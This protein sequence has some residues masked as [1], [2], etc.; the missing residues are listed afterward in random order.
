M[1]DAAVLIDHDG[2][3]WTLTLNR[4]RRLNALD[5]GDR[6]ELLAALRNADADPGCRAVVLTGAGGVFSAGGDIRSMSQAPDETPVRLAVLTDLA[7]AVI[8]SS[9]PVIAAV[10]GGAFGLGLSLTA[11]A[12]YVV[13]ANDARFIASFG[14]IGLIGDTGLFWSLAQRVGSSRAKELMLFATE[15]DASRAHELGLVNEMTPPAEV[16]STARERAHTLA[17]AAPGVIAGT[18]RIFAQE[19]QDL[20]AVLAAETETQLALLAGDD[21]AEGRA[22]FLERRRPVFTGN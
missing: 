14:K 6:R 3:V 17:L 8:R 4:P 10:E 21:Y 19:H 5:L 18:K 1:T 20:D 13:A 15:L 12:D 7:R 9:I 2:P 22:A 16:L 11:A